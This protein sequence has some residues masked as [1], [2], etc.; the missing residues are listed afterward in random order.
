M[1]PEFSEPDSPPALAT[2][3][4]HTQNSDPISA[5]MPLGPEC[6]WELCCVVQP[7][8]PRRGLGKKICLVKQKTC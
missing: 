1:L 8:G 7:P 5:A 6:R 3:F 2:W 4:T